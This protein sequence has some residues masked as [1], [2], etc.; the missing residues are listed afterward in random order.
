MSGLYTRYIKIAKIDKNGN[1]NTNALSSLTTITIPW[2]D[3]SKARYK[4]LGISQQQDYFAYTVEYQSTSSIYQPDASTLDYNFSGSFSTSSVFV[5]KSS[6]V[7]VNLPVEKIYPTGSYLFSINKPHFVT[8]SINQATIYFDTYP[9]KDIQIQF[10]GSAAAGATSDVNVVGTLR[11]SNGVAI[12]P[13]TNSSTGTNQ[14]LENIPAGATESFNV[15]WNIPS[16]SFDPGTSL[17]ITAFTTNNNST[18]T[19]QPD[20]FLNISSSIG[21]RTPIQAVLEP[22]LDYKFRDSN[23]DVLQGNVIESRPNP[24]IQDI[25]YTN[26]QI[27]P[28]NYQ[29][30]K[31]YNAVRGTYPESN[32]TITSILNPSYGSKNQTIDFN[33]YQPLGFGGQTTTAFGDPINIGTLGQTPSAT[34]SSNFVVYFKTVRITPGG[35]SKFIQKFEPSYI[36]TPDESLLEITS[37]NLIMEQLKQVFNPIPFPSSRFGD[38]TGPLTF[39]SVSFSSTGSYVG[40]YTGIGGVT[41]GSSGEIFLDIFSDS[42]GGFE[43]LPSGFSYVRNAGGL[44]FPASI[45]FSETPELPSK[46]KELLSKNNLI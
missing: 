40:N 5:G 32:F 9:Q 42:S 37:D 43:G 28:S 36:I 24:H 17:G 21:T 1:N 2:S 19:L 23:C 38:P 44:V 26:S 27:L 33:V 3:G 22:F 6:V 13:S 15:I 30:L 35:G 46:A 4:I 41:T 11:D 10:S 7:N 29:A 45:E 34:I 18:L 20:V 12:S 14:L 16:S 8:P 39:K 25:D 31:N